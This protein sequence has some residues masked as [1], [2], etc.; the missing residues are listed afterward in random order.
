MKLARKQITIKS[1]KGEGGKYAPFKYNTLI[2]ILSEL[3]RRG[4]NYS[5]DLQRTN[6]GY[7]I[8]RENNTV[9]FKKIP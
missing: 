5:L 8:I 2:D 7:Y 4:I 1:A 3:I 6:C 9:S